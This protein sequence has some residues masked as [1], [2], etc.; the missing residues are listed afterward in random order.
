MQKSVTSYFQ[1]HPRLRRDL[2]VFAAYLLV[3][4]ALFT[5][6]DYGNRDGGDSWGHYY[7]AINGRLGYYSSRPTTL[8]P[9]ALFA[10]VFDT[11]PIAG[12][13]FVLLGRCVNACL[14]YL[15][16]RQLLLTHVQFSY[17][18]GFI[19]LL[20]FVPDWFFLLNI[21]SIS[22]HLLSLTFALI[23]IYLF[24]RS[25][26]DLSYGMLFISGLFCLL[27]SG[28]REALL[29]LLA[30]I[31]TLGIILGRQ[32]DRSTFFKL[33]LWG[34]FI[35]ISAAWYAIP[36][37]GLGSETYFS[38]FREPVSLERIVSRLSL[39]TMFTLRPLFLL[40]ASK[41][42]EYRLPIILVNTSLLLT[43]WFVLRSPDWALGQAEK[44][45]YWLQNLKKPLLWLGLGILV[46]FL[47][48]F[49]FLLTIVAD[50]TI[51]VHSTTP[52]GVAVIV[53]AI[54]W[55]IS[56]LLPRNWLRQA[57]AAMV[58]ITVGTIGAV[59]VSDLQGELYALDSVWSDQAKYFRTLTHITPDVEEGTLFIHIQPQG[60][61][62]SPFIFGVG[63]QYAVQV[64]Y[65]EKARALIS[66]DN[67]A[68]SDWQITEDGVTVTQTHP[69]P[70][71]F[72]FTDQHYNWD[73]VIF[74]TKNTDGQAVIIEDISARSLAEFGV[75]N[76]YVD[77]SVIGPEAESS[78]APYERI[79]PG[80]VNEQ[81]QQVYP[82]LLDL[83]R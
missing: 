22:D 16:M 32:Y 71:S 26:D 27:A 73:Q 52:I 66:N 25:V 5:V 4:A 59:Q 37:L 31:P 30:G 57:L 1:S 82:P 7:S 35:S 62:D 48:L 2:M 24:F 46:W 64:L 42:T 69:G 77:L 79:R 18:A 11:A 49:A 56:E 68:G 40:Q 65:E 74:I 10:F 21:F 38:G 61:D 3:T 39:Q 78:Y 14:V 50:T 34:V 51:R 70:P 72:L 6:I 83:N 9:V 81:V 17:M 54:V 63:L 41:L 29:P 53:T 47:G 60:A 44:D 67:M 43:S 75:F 19:Y 23:A 80:Y 36:I 55:L 33:C 8:V 28:M 45:R 20:Y 15:N 13:I 58:L 76:D 12:H